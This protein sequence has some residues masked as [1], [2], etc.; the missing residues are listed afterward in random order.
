MATFGVI[1]NDGKCTPV[2]N[3][4]RGAK[5]YAT[6]NGFDKIGQ[7]SGYSMTVYGIQAKIN[8]KWRAEL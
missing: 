2:A 4:E 7:I 8:G 6:R 1:F 5:N 3:S